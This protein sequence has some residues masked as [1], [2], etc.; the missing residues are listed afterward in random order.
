MAERGERGIC[1]LPCPDHLPRKLLAKLRTG[2]PSRRVRL[3]PVVG[4]L[5][6][7]LRARVQSGTALLGNKS[8]RRGS[9]GK[10]YMLREKGPYH[11]QKT[12]KDQKQGHLGLGS[13][14]IFFE[15]AFL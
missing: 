13:S 1:L 8:E 11:S 7:G 14:T 6:T 9:W 2:S 4:Y 15:M 10:L 3:G 12:E 5:F